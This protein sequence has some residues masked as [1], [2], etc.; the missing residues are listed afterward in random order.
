M[1]RAAE[2]DL[3]AINRKRASWAG[4]ALRAFA[5]RTGAEMPGEALPDF[6]V[7]LG[8]YADRHDID[9][10]AVVSRALGTWAIETEEPQGVSAARHVTIV[11][12]PHL[13][14]HGDHHDHTLQS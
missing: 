11:I 7:D 2:V 13:S 6:I 14:Q 4:T 3:R 9:F 10:L 5:R 8:H 1:S 12:H